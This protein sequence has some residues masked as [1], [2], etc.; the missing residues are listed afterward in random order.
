MGPKKVVLFLEINLVKISLSLTA[1]IVR[2]CIRTFI[3]FKKKHTRTQTQTKS[4][5]K[6]NKRKTKE[7]NK[8]RENIAVVNSIY[9]KI[10]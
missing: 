6:L 8:K 9:K 7:T 10:F 3:C 4:K 1:H 5:K 2:M